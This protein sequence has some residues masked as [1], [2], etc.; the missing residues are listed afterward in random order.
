M[1]A[2]TQRV[3]NFLGGVSR[4]SDDEKVP[5]QVTELI[6]GYPDPTFGLTKRAGFKWIANLS[7]TNTTKYDN[8]K[9]FYINRDQD[10]RYIGCITVGDE[11]KIYVWNIDGTVC[12]VSQPDLAYIDASSKDSYHVITAQDVSIITNSTKIISETP[13]T[14][15][16]I[17]GSQATLLLNG[18]L[19]ETDLYADDIT[20]AYL[21]VT[22]S[23]TITIN[24]TDYTVDVTSNAVTETEDSADYDT[25]NE[26]LTQLKTE[27]EGLASSGLNLSCKVYNNTLEIE[28]KENEDYLPFEITCKA[29]KNGD[30]LR[31]LHKE[32]QNL[33]ELPR[34]SSDGRVIELVNTSAAEDN[35]FIKFISSDNNG[36]GHWEE[37]RNPDAKIGLDKTTMPHQLINTA[38]NTFIFKSIDY[39]DRLTGTGD[40]KVNSNPAPSFVGNTINQAFFQN[41]RLG[42]LSEDNVVLSQAGDFYNFYYTSAQTITA[43]DPIDI[44]CTTTRPVKLHGV[45]PT[46]QGT[47]LFSNN[48]QFV[49]KAN[50]GLFTPR[51]TS[52][53][54]I[55]NYETDSKTDPV[56]MGTHINFISKTPSYT[57]VFSMATQGQE[58]SPTIVDIGKSVNEWVPPTIDTII[59]NP[60][61]G[62]LAMSS[63]SSKDIY[64][65]KLHV[66]GNEI[67]MQAWFKWTLCGNVQ[68][69]FMDDDDI[70]AVTIQGNGQYTLSSASVSQSPEDAII[71]N[72]NGVKVNPCIDLYAPASSVISHPI[73]KI[74]INNGGEY[75][76]A[77]NVQV[78]I[79]ANL[80]SGSGVTL[81][82][83]NPITYDTVT[84]GETIT[85]KKI[86]SIN[87]DNHGSNYYSGA[88]VTITG[89]NI[90]THADVQAEVYKGSWC[91]FPKT[92]DVYLDNDE[93]LTSCLIIKG[94]GEGDAS[95]WKESGFAILPTID[96][97]SN[98]NYYAK[99][100]NKNLVSQAADVFLGWQYDFDVHLPKT[101]F[102]FG[103]R[104]MA[105]DI[106]AS[107]TIARMK[108]AS[109]LSGVLSF[110]LKTKGVIQGSKAYV[111][112]GTTDTFGWIDEDINNVDR[113]EI[114]VKINNSQ[115][116]NPTDWVFVDDHTIKLNSIPSTTLT[117]SG[118][119]GTPTRHTFKWTFDRV[120]LGKIKV[121]ISTD[122]G[123]TWTEQTRNTD[124]ISALKPVSVSAVDHVGEVVF[125]EPSTTILDGEQFQTYASKD[126]AVG[127]KVRIYSADD[128]LI[129]QDEWYRIRPIQF[130]DDY[131][132]SDVPL[133]DHNI[134]TVPIHQRSK[135][136]QLRVFNDSPFPVALNSM[137]WEGIYSPRQYRRM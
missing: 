89:D 115:V 103:D 134:F 10:E 27:I 105:S 26:L 101:Y 22:Y 97:D 42:F 65:N 76:D 84:E 125:I 85:S 28:R 107:L 34:Q 111:G 109:G 73:E 66:T 104:G 49:M 87:I 90:T 35:F 74:I 75:K 51:T 7:E 41:N 2:I 17:I 71:V 37:T 100:P 114:K 108:F 45:V 91:Y 98:N 53:R 43:A 12:T 16:D 121:E 24:K 80:G 119:A 54:A 81:D 32:A 126:L 137:T 127:T 116:V 4:Q 135:N 118:D 93:T 72:T 92:G 62:I 50:D 3:D 40:D 48:Q 60:Q 23:V 25:A 15:T 129:Y 52:I 128:I 46:T 57:R 122:D 11:K 88:T 39:V 30:K 8:A 56:D 83:E 20:G 78:T 86:Q 5:G 6:N 132:V 63:Q 112:D 120:D 70:Y 1:T 55:S 9:W 123:V 96:K 110:K 133:A 68:T 18:P 36:N 102:R 64:L 13:P 79:N 94:G 67:V 44:P 99:V 136:F 131:L 19:F 113:D 31:L 29:G 21:K 130:A 33:T 106:G 61:N 59:A 82:S 124:F 14:D 47:I 58:D 95:L 77:T 117:A 38:L 69:M